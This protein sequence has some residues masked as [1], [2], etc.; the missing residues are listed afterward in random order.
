MAKVH[1]SEK[2]LPKGSAPWMTRVH[3]RYGQ[4]T[5]GFAITERNVVTFG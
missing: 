3:K 1:S 4:T 5:D 2:I